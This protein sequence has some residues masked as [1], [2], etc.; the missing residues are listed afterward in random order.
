MRARRVPPLIVR[1]LPLLQRLSLHRPRDARKV[2]CI[3]GNCM[4]ERLGVINPILSLARFTNC[5]DTIIPGLNIQI[6]LSVASSMV[7]GVVSNAGLSTPPLGLLLGL[8]AL[9]TG[10]DS[11]RRD[12]SIKEGAV[13]GAAVK[14][15]GSADDTNGL[16]VLLKEMLD[17]I[18]A[19]RAGF[20]KSAS[21]TVVDEVANVRGGDL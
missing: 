8:Q 18:T 15:G 12:A 7:V 4:G 2:L 9:G 3:S 1:E 16:E 13:V 6:R 20:V 10:E 5:H 14:A 19:S 21:I 11:S 17:M